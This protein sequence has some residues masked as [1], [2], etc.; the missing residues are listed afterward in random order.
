MNEPRQQLLKRE[1]YKAIKHM[2]REEM[3]RYLYRVWQRGFE[4]G[5]K[6]IKGADA[7]RSIAPPEQAQPEE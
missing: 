7:K 5:V 4:A 6:S 2:N 3:T 1:D